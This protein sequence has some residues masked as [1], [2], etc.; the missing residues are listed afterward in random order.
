MRAFSFLLGPLILIGLSFQALVIMANSASAQET[1]PGDACTTAGAFQRSGGPEIAGGHFLVCDGANW[2]TFVD[3]ADT[4]RS[5]LQ[6]DNDT[7]AC[8]AAKMGR[9]RYVSASDQ[10][11]YCDGS[12]W[13]ALTGGAGGANELD[14][15]SDAVTDYTA[16]VKNVFVGE[17]AGNATTVGINSVGIGVGALNSLDS[18]CGGFNECDFNTAVGH[19][20]LTANTKGKSNSALGA[21]ALPT[22]TT[23]DENTAIG[24][25]SMR[26]TTTGSWNTGV[27]FQALY[28]NTT[29]WNN[30]AVGNSALYTNDGNNNTAVGRDALTLNTFGNNNVALGFE[31]LYRNT[32]TDSSVAIGYQA[33]REYTPP[34]GNGY[35]VAVGY[36]ALFGSWGFSNGQRNT[37]LGSLAGKSAR[38]GD[39]NVFVGYNAG[40]TTTN[41]HRNILIGSGVVAS[42]AGADDELNIGDLIYGDLAN[43]EVFLDAPAAAAADGD[44]AN[45]QV[46]FWVDAANNEIELKAK[47]SAGDVI[48]VTVGGGGGVSAID[49]LSDAITDYTD[50]N[51]FLGQNAGGAITNGTDNVALGP[52]ALAANTSGNDNTAVGLQALLNNTGGLNNTAVG[53]NALFSN[54]TGGS[55]VA[56]GKSALF[57]NAGGI[58]NTATGYSAL[59]SNTTGTNNTATGDGVLYN[60]T[61]GN[62]NTAMGKEAGGN[63]AATDGDMDGNS[64]FGYQAGYDLRGGASGAGANYNTL[65]GYMAGQNVTLGDDNTVIGT[66]A[67]VTLTT[68]LRNIII[69]HDA[70]VSAAG[71]NDELNIGDVLYGDLAN[72]YIGINVATPTAGLEIDLGSTTEVNT[73]LVVNTEST[74]GNGNI[75]E[76]SKA[77][78][79]EVMIDNSGLVGFG[80]NTSPNVEVDVTGDIEFTGTITD[81]SDIRLKE[82][83]QPLEDV[84]A[85]LILLQGI[86]FTMKDDITGRVEFGISAQELQKQFPELVHTAKDEMGTLSVNYVGLIAPMIEA[87]KEQQK[88]IEALRAENK[89]LTARIDKLEE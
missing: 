71:A 68:G 81:V 65:M 56:L 1:S 78:T 46:T 72:G 60:N 75:A 5:L 32:D 30:V 52:D 88:Q 31:A 62:S 64:L 49:D 17:N 74:T 50:N 66:D 36:Q 57:S 73:A 9:L 79:I 44:L 15:L 80:G 84:L 53:G 18:T 8:A 35:N 3:Y 10:W 51:M 58:N 76:F 12:N 69:G 59:F 16:G 41:G 82:N 7:G 20:A 29:G 28:W 67:G 11:D 83:I 40:N 42:T 22:A 37:A 24:E 87:I 45:G 55:N 33:L 23:A 38:A 21:Y 19:S 43:N 89:A 77:G 27:G 2:L 70:D 26:N 54:T 13:T 61:I 14:D 63:S 34:A 86:S 6:I 39:D 48:N 85:R 4:G 25:S 47:D